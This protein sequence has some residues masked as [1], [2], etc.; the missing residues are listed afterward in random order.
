VIVP[1]ASPQMQPTMPG[2][3]VSTIGNGGSRAISWSTRELEKI[4]DEDPLSA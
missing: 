4:Q 1:R 2:R 3:F